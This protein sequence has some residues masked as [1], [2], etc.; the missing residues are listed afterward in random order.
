MGPSNGQGSVNNIE[1]LGGQRSQQL[2]GGGKL[3]EPPQNA[4]LAARLSGLQGHQPRPGLAVLGHQ[5]RLAG[6]G[7]ID[8]SGDWVLAS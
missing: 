5:N 7:G 1:L 2:F 4:G 8:Q 6:M 3:E